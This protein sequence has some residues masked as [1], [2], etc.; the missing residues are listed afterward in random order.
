M[1]TRGSTQSMN[2]TSLNRK[3]RHRCCTKSPTAQDMFWSIPGLISWAEVTERWE[4]KALVHW[5]CDCWLDTTRKALSHH[6]TPI[7]GRE[8]GLGTRLT[9]LMWVEAISC[10]FAC[11]DLY[12]CTISCTCPCPILVVS[13]QTF[14]FCVLSLLFSKTTMDETLSRKLICLVPLFCIVMK[15]KFYDSQWARVYGSAGEWVA[16]VWAFNSNRSS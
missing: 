6:Q 3:G 10:T 14:Q 7:L 11:N 4:K 1:C 12:V 9:G 15:L 5:N 16:R 2:H 13:N 8:W